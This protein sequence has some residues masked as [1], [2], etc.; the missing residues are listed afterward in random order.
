MKS[1]RARPSPWPAGLAQR[2]S[3]NEQARPLRE[4][5]LDRLLEREA[6]TARIAHGREAAPQDA[7]HDRQRLE[8]DE[9]VGHVH[10]ARQIELRRDHMRV[11]VDQARHDGFALQID[12]LRAGC[13]DRLRRDFLD[14]AAFD[15]QIVTRLQS[16]MQWIE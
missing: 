2:A 13:V 4:A 14:R 1:V 3:G 7:A 12:D 16:M 11:Q 15:E 8:R 9:Y 10:L 5:H 6:G